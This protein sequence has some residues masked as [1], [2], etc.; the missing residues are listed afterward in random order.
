M[1]SLQEAVLVV[2]EN[3][4]I[5]LA[6][7]AVKEIFPNSIEAE[8]R[9]LGDV[10]KSVRLI[11]YVDSVRARRAE[12]RKEIEFFHEGKPVWAEVSG[13]LVK[14]L[15]EQDG[16][17]V[18]FVLHDITRQKNLENARREFVAS[19][20]HELRT[21]LSVIKGYTETLVEEHNEMPSEVRSKFLGAIQRHAD[22]LSLIVED[23]LTLSRLEAKAEESVVPTLNK[24]KDFLYNTLDEFKRRPASAGYSFSFFVEDGIGEL[25]FDCSRMMQVMENLLE[26]AR[27]YSPEGTCI[28]V[29]AKLDG[30]RV[31]VCVRDNGIGIPE[32]DIP[33]LFERFY[34]VDK[35]RSRE[36][37]GTGLG[38]SIVKHIVQL[39]GGE[40]GV[41]SKL[42]EG[43][44]FWFTLPKKAS[45]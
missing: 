1:G 38:L 19:V 29:E 39:H 45:L 42:G 31:R 6:N 13:T 16:Q 17:W 7:A 36:R 34:R 44:E 11:D 35:G 33:R 18:L 12:A 22:R 8:G 2:D 40:V 28:G 25:W 10:L 3:D 15:D 5:V 30:D 20:S 26:N 4:V 37:G 21:P 32:K 9:S 23:L 43:S 41:K 24:L 27:K 14:S